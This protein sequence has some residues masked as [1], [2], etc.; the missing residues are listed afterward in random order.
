MR[1]VNVKIKDEEKLKRI[2]AKFAGVKSE[3]GYDKRRSKG[4]HL[5]CTRTSIFW[6][7]KVEF[8]FISHTSI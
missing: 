7:L 5:V 4:Q 6:K 8:S 3:K 2:M 1:C